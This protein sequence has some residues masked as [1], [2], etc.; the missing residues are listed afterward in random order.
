MFLVKSPRQHSQP[1]CKFQSAGQLR[2]T[3]LTTRLAFACPRL[4]D[5]RGLMFQLRCFRDKVSKCIRRQA[6]I[7]DIQR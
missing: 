3:P 2:Q 6:A 5:R 1:L 7:P 4:T